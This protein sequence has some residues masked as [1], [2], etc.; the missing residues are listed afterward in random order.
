MRRLFLFLLLLVVG[1][2]P[3]MAAG[4]T[5]R[6]QPDKEGGTPIRIATLQSRNTVSF[7]PPNEEEQPAHL[8]FRVHPRHGRDV[9]LGLKK[10]RFAC[11][12]DECGVL[13]RFDEKP[14]KRF[15]AAA[16]GDSSTNTVFIRDYGGFI[17]AVRTAKK[18]VIEAAFYQQGTRTFEFEVEG[19]RF[20]DAYK[21]ARKAA[22][23]Q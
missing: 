18:V 8:T 12:F 13:V 15:A 11:R 20:D 6:D 23:R 1:A 14:A 22:S 21:P 19:L 9:L 10:A 5:Y 4:W 17:A 7:A 3:A 2:A 16:P